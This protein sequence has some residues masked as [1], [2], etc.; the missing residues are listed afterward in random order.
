LIADTSFIIDIM[1]K[2]PAAIKKAQALEET[3]LS[4]V[5]GTPTLFELFAGVAQSRKP[6]EEKSKIITTLSSISQL[7]LDSPSASAGGLIYG[8]KTRTG[9]TIDPED[10]MIAGIAKVK[11]PS[12]GLI[13]GRRRC[14]RRIC[15]PTQ[16]NNFQRGIFCLRRG[17]REHARPDA[18]RSRLGIDENDALCCRRGA[19]TDRRWYCREKRFEHVAVLTYLFSA[20]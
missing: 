7:S 10:A 19:T 6:E 17:E 2:D 8:E 5:I 9:R 13:V 20:G 1:A 11:S 4:I 3:G 12:N 16:E 15:A 18:E 14:W